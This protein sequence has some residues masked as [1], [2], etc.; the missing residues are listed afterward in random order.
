LNATWLL[1]KKYIY[2]L[3]L[4]LAPWSQGRGTHWLFGAEQYS[5]KAFTERVIAIAKDDPL[6]FYREGNYGVTFYAGRR[7]PIYM[8]P[9]RREPSAFYLLCWE[10]EWKE[11]RDT[12]GLSLDYASDHIDRQRPERGHLYLITVHRQI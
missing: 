11:I 10:D 8:K 9:L 5:Y 4:R 6:Y 3:L 12:K 1:S 7:I 2:G